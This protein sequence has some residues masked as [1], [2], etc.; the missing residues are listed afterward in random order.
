MG[1]AQAP[2]ARLTGILPWFRLHQA[3]K[4]TNKYLLYSWVV[5]PHGIPKFQVF[6][7]PSGTVS[8][9]AG[10]YERLVSF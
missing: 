9:G 6:V 8:I 3:P 10:D 1:T 7:G 4:A 5:L 2:P